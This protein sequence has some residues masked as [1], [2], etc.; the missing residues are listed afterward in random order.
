MARENLT[1]N[2]RVSLST[3]DYLNSFGLAAVSVNIGVRMDTGKKTSDFVTSWKQATLQTSKSYYNEGF[4]SV[5]VVTGDV[6]GVFVLD[7]DNNCDDKGN[8]LE[9][10]DLMTFRNETVRTWKARTGSGGLHV[11]FK[12]PSAPI[13]NLRN[14]T[15]LF[16]DDRVWGIDV[17]ANG[18]I[19]FCPPSSYVGADRT[20]R[21]YEWVTSPSECDLADIPQWL[22][23]IL[24]TDDARKRGRSCLDRNID[25][26]DSDGESDSEST[27]RLTIVEMGSILRRHP[28]YPDCS[29]EFRSKVKDNPNLYSFRVSSPRVCIYGHS[30]RGSNNFS[31]LRC[32]R[33]LF[34]ICHGSECSKRKRKLLGVLSLEAWMERFSRCKLTYADSELL[35]ILNDKHVVSST[36]SSECNHRAM[37]RMLSEV[38]KRCGRVVSCE[39]S[40]YVWQ[41]D[42]WTK[43]S[44]LHMR[45]LCC[46]NLDFIVRAYSRRLMLS[47]DD[48]KRAKKVEKM[49]DKIGNAS[50]VDGTLKLLMPFV[51]QPDFCR[52]LNKDRD[53]LALKNGVLNVR[54]GKFH[55]HHPKY[56]CTFH[57]DAEWRPTTSTVFR[58]FVHDIFNGDDDVIEYIQTMF[59][60]AITGHTS[61]QMFVILHGFGSNGKSVLLNSLKGALGKYYGSMHRDV[62]LEGPKASRGAADPN[63]AVLENTRLAVCEET[64]EKNR[65]DDTIVKNISGETEIVTRNL[66]ETT[67]SFIPTFQPILATNHKPQ[68][69]VAD[70]ALLRRLVLIPFT[71]TYVPGDRYNPALFPNH[72][73]LDTS[74]N[75][76]LAS[77]EAKAEIVQ[78]L[79]E[80]AQKWYYKRAETVETCG[81]EKPVLRS[82]PPALDSAMADYQN[83]ND[84]VKQFVDENCEVGPRWFVKSS[85]M[86]YRYREV[87]QDDTMTA[88]GMAAALKRLGFDNN[89]NKPIYDADTKESVRGFRG[90]R[91][92]PL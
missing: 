26:W 21:S 10:W 28:K 59:G 73:L 82:K 49:L 41:G 44:M 45:G 2:G 52:S 36:F 6:S 48:K 60:Y 84:P 43:V 22:V 37:A 11:Y 91:M 15:S 78:W 35:T 1:M 92:L 30:H 75:R 7:I 87:T 69:N 77:D 79:A 27:E 61:E 32:N 89:K 29:S 14:R 38:Y 24:G 76:R 40:F 3:F 57:A 8:G 51:E 83:E 23:E 85:E 42:L 88:K 81:V 13:I 67:K 50:F 25:S 31:I 71:N 90:L 54:T 55:R 18:G 4:N 63:M 64:G 66:Y 5:A 86:L 17:R 9:G 62:I 12:M 34:Y 80:G 19:A 47:E 20:L 68:I 53:V 70:P 65:L 56:L 72:R 46:E 39:D 33:E 16:Y 58:D 74:L